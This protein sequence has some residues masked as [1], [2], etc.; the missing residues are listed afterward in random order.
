MLCGMELM[1]G[2]VLIGGGSLY[3]NCSSQWCQFHCPPL[4][5][6]LPLRHPC[7]LQYRK[8]S[9]GSS[10]KSTAFLSP[11]SQVSRETL[12]DRLTLPPP[13][14]AH[15]SCLSDF[16][17]FKNMEKPYLLVG[18]RSFYIEYLREWRDIRAESDNT[19]TM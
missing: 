13:L 10:Q 6:S 15:S 3:R 18:D 17:S 19:T 16:N 8:T 1:E 11:Y 9:L 12:S 7:M 14:E 4:F 2:E 5:H